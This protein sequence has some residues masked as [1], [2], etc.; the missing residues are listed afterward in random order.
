MRHPSL[1]SARVISCLLKVA[2]ALQLTMAALVVSGHIGIR[3]RLEHFEI[4]NL[5]TANS[6]KHQSI[7]DMTL[8]TYMDSM[9][10]VLDFG[11]LS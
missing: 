3:L 10:T 7:T 1:F 2:L 8:R 6:Q 9:D 5:L 4:D 11:A